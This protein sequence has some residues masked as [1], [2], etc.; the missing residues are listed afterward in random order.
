MKRRMLEGALVGA[1]LTGSLIAVSCLGWQLGGLPF[2]PFDLFDWIARELPGSVV[3]AAIESMVGIS[4][5]LHVGNIGTAAKGAE[6]VL[7][8]A[9]LL[10]VGT[11]AASVLFGVLGFSDEPTLLLG[12]ILGAILG[13]LAV[14]VEQRTN[15]IALGSIVSVAWVVGTFVAWGLAFGWIHDRLHTADNPANAQAALDGS[16]DRRRFLVRLAYATGTPTL[17][18][19]LWGLVMGSRRASVPGA[20]WSDDHA[21]PNGAATVAPVVGTRPEF[22]R[23]EDHYRI[24]TNTRVPIIDANTWRL[25]IGGLVDHPLELTLADIRREQ[26]LDQF[27]TLSC[28]SNPI[29]GDLIG[30]TRWTGVS[31][32]RLLDR[33]ILLQPRATHVRITSADGFFE[34]LPLESIRNDPRVMLTYAWDGVPL[35]AEHGFPLRIY[36]PDRYGMKQPK[37]IVAIDATDHWEPG[38]W[39]MRGWD[40]EGRMQATSVVDAI[41]VR[42][43]A[44]DPSGERIVPVGGIAHAGARRVSRVEARLDG[45]QWREA[46]IRDPLSDTT[47]AVWRADLPSEPGDHVVSVRCYEG[48]GTPQ[49]GAIHNKRTRL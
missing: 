1:L 46:R 13:H 37:W 35:L 9:G 10:V 7:A 16:I 6:Q 8:I 42:A 31:V 25:K 48:D 34:C 38:Y 20:R 30:T 28:I 22:T 49:A 26:P 3:T 40:R 29:G 24:D 32:Q 45:G 12:A 44:A 14:L 21:L 15:R 4:R 18:T 43:A 11:L 17:L 5:A 39:V 36:I 2:V 27:V 33:I 41:D 23:L 47:W 19:A